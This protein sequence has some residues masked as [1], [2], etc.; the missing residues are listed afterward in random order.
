[1]VLVGIALTALPQ[2]SAFAGPSKPL[3][4]CSSG[5]VLDVGLLGSD[6]LSSCDLTG[7]LVVVADF[8]FTVPEVGEGVGQA[9]VRTVDSDRALPT[10]VLLYHSKS[11]GVAVSVDGSQPVG[12]PSAIKEMA[13]ERAK[14]RTPAQTGSLVPMAKPTWCGSVSQYDPTGQKWTNGIYQWKH[15]SSG[16]PSSMTEVQRAAAFDAAE[17]YIEADDN[18][19]GGSNTSL[20][21][22]EV[23]S[24]TKTVTGTAIMR[25]VEQGALDLDTPIRA[26]LPALRLA[27]EDV[28]AN[29]TLRHLLT[30]TGGWV[31]DFF[32]DTGWGD[33]ALQRAVE[34]MVELPQLTPLGSTFHYSNS[35]FYLLGRIIEVATGKTYEAAARELVLAPL[36]MTNSFFFPHEVMLRRFVVGHATLEDKT[37]ILEPWPIARAANAVGGLTSS[38]R[39]QLRYARFHMGDGVAETGERLL[40]PATMV[41]M[42]SPLVPIDT[43]GGYR[44]LSWIVREV[45]GVKTVAHGG[46]TLGQLSAF[47]FAPTA[48]F[49]LTVLTNSQQGGE[50]NTEVTQWALEHYLGA[51]DADP[52]ALSLAESD[53]SAYAGFYEGRLSDVEISVKDGGLVVQGIPKGG[54]P[55]ETS[56]APPAPPLARFAVIGPDQV[57]GLESP[58]KDLR[59]EFLRGPDGEIVWFRWGGRILRRCN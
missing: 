18:A 26:Y 17:G 49:A 19:C 51:K 14:L 34:R 24:T 13:D 31:G 28:A 27:D 55:D 57:I 29:A 6:A 11:G 42:Q 22:G 3:T 48:G 8:S 9:A 43:F 37:I 40:S 44:G 21:V 50:L 36:G 33:D 47:I 56:P 20:S 23:G 1:M 35:S 53:L 7:R 2:Q 10:T 45:G 38:A 58:V 4:T 16:R 59:G 54:F 15:N 5:G 12:A 52:V 46:A 30:H 39:D 32:I 41:E 25:L